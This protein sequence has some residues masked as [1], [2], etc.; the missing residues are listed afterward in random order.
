MRPHRPELSTQAAS[1]RVT[2]NASLRGV[3]NSVIENK[4]VESGESE[5]DCSQG[6][7][8]AGNVGWVSTH[9]NEA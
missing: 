5:Q 8:S 3:L 4:D 2:A 1:D 6:R 7:V 9:M